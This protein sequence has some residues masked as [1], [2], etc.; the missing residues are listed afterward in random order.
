V[1]QGSLDPPAGLEQPTR[2]V[3]AHLTDLRREHKLEAHRT[4]L[5]RT[6]LSRVS[7]RA[8]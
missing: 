8:A 3:V 6:V 2:V 7:R 5:A 4:A 1:T